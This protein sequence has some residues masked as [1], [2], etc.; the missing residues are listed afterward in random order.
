MI[1]AWLSPFNCFPVNPDHW[2]VSSGYTYVPV[3]NGSPICGKNTP[4]Q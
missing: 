4:P 3:N 1:L 2:D